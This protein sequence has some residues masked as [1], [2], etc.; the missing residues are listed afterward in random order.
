MA[1]AKYDALPPNARK[2]IDANS[3]ESASRDFGRMWDTV[4]E[5]AR[6]LIKKTAG[7]QL[8]SPSDA[9]ASDMEKKTEPVVDDWLAATP[10]GRE[11]LDQFNAALAAVAAGK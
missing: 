11:T 6:Q 3:G 7:Q 5:R 2:I 8:V 4:A 1:K 9:E 10:D